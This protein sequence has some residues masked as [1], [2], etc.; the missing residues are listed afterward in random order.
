MKQKNNNTF[1]N[2]ILGGVI[3]TSPDF[4]MHH[5]YISF[6]AIT[7]GSFMTHITENQPY[8]KR[9]CGIDIW[10]CMRQASQLMQSSH[11]R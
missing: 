3:I 5:Y 1:I 9:S 8:G 4:S 6:S 2:K 7:Y 10:S 11:L